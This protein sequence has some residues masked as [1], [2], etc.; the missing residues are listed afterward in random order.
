MSR[1]TANL[2]IMGNLDNYFQGVNSTYKMAVGRSTSI[3][4]PY[5]DKN[6]MNMMYGGGTI[7]DAGNDRWRGPGHSDIL[8]NDIIVRHAYDA[9]ANGTP[10]LLINDL[11]WDSQG[12]S[13]Y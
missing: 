2:S 13:T 4:G 9:L 7:F 6:G 3:T 5:Y 8:N 10:N 11:N 1:V 12:W